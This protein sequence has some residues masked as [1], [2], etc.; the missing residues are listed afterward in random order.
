MDGLKITAETQKG[1]EVIE[2]YLVEKGKL[3]VHQKLI[4]H[5]TWETKT[6]LDEQKGGFKAMFLYCKTRW[7]GPEATRATLE[8]TFKELGATKKD[9]KIKKVSK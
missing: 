3:P 1:K 6:E 9:Y 7:V 8:E 2:K 5:N 4:Y